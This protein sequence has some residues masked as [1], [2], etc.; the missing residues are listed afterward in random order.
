MGGNA[1]TWLGAV[2]RRISI[3]SS[4]LSEMKSARMMGLSGFLTA[5]IQDE[6]N[7]ET[8]LMSSYQRNIVSKNVLASLP[9]IWA[10]WVT[11]SVYALQ[12][13]AS[14]SDSIDTNKGFT[15]LAIISL[16]S[17][18][19][20]QL[21]DSIITTFARIASFDRIQS[22]LISES[23]RDLRRLSVQETGT[24]GITQS[25]TQPGE[26]GLSPKESTADKATQSVAISVARA[27]IR[28]A[29]SADLILRDISFDLCQGSLTMIVGRVGSGK[30]TLLRALLGEI[31]CSHGR[32]S[33][34]SL[35]VAYCPGSAWLPNT[36]IRRAICGP[37]DSASVD[38][39][40]YQSTLKACALDY[41]LSMLS[42]GDQ[43][44][45]GSGSTVLS[46]GQ[47]QRVALAR[48]VYSRLNIMLFDDVLSALDAKTKRT[49]VERLLLNKD[50]LLK[51]LGSTTILIVN[52]CQCTNIYPV[53]ILFKQNSVI[54]T[55][56]PPPATLLAY[57]DNII[58]LADGGIKFQ[59][60]YQQMVC[61][62]ISE[63]VEVRGPDNIVEG[64]IAKAPSFHEERTREVTE[65]AQLQDLA[66]AT[67][68]IEVYKY[69]FK[70]I[71][72]WK[73]L[74]FVGLTALYACSIQLSS[75]CYRR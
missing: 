19:A 51:K 36:T 38:E 42:D 31:S 58:I 22:Y 21:I 35:R 71:G 40:W 43:T 23:R 9:L 45:I 61:C 17:T 5:K 1:K 37:R 44:V 33:L 63:A 75:K 64:E 8:Q 59:G 10:P 6:R 25:Y 62:G 47:R 65:P 12:A 20:F 55:A 3:T 69:Y 67:G 11:F 30:T 18:P 48:A 60:T 32:I 7:K 29:P 41:D 57:A 15:S 16:V 70:C 53:S 46:G 26:K 24:L 50:G 39:V 66:R 52:D 28:P 27:D 72:L 2:Q 13:A 49:V 74:V 54:S 34:S 56:D 73:S 4:V 14:G 68:D